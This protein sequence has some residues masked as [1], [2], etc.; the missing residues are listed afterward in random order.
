M[1][2]IPLDCHLLKEKYTA[3]TR[4]HELVPTLLGHIATVHLPKITKIV[5][6]C[7]KEISTHMT[8]P[9]DGSYLHVEQLKG[10]TI[11]S[12]QHINNINRS[13][14]TKPGRPIFEDFCDL[15]EIFQ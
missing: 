7:I 1:K 12:G 14:I 9:M 2:S 11:T 3:T 5:K 6:P 15:K 13:A 8:N 10:S 4:N